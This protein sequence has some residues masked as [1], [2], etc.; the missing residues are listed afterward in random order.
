VSAGTNLSNF[1]LTVNTCTWDNA[2]HNVTVV[3]TIGA[4]C[5]CTFNAVSLGAFAKPGQE[6]RVG[7]LSAANKVITFDPPASGNAPGWYGFRLVLRLLARLTD[8]A[9][10]GSL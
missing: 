7:T 1:C 3:F 5:N 9:L 2:A 10:T 8:W 4:G 6:C